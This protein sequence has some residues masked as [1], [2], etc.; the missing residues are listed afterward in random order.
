MMNQVQCLI[1]ECLHETI[2]QTY[3]KNS[4]MIEVT[5]PQNLFTFMKIGGAFS[6]R[7]LNAENVC[8]IIY[9]NVFT[10]SMIYFKY[11][12]TKQKQSLM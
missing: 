10:N 11:I 6:I 5:H 2:K 1:N 8:I 7:E 3:S 12:S 4:E 9:T